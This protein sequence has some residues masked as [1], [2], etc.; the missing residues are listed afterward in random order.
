MKR[1]HNPAMMAMMKFDSARAIARVCVSAF[2]APDWRGIQGMARERYK[3]DKKRGFCIYP[4]VER[5]IV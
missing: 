5:R 1:G 4:S 3:C 2:M